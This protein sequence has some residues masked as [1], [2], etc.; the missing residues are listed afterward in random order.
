[1]RVNNVQGSLLALTDGKGIHEGCYR[2]R[3]ENR[4]PACNHQGML[5]L[6]IFTVQ[7]DFRQVED[8]KEIRVQGFIGQ[9]DPDDLKISQG[10]FIL[11]AEQGNARIAHGR[12]HIYPGGKGA[13]CSNIDPLVKQVIQYRNPQVGLTQ[14]INIRKH[15]RHM[16]L[17]TFPGLDDLVQLTPDIAPRLGHSRQEMFNP[18]LQALCLHNLHLKP[19]PYTHRHPPTTAHP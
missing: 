6:T 15:Q 19:I 10:T 5:G 9:A 1:M 11:Q 2:F 8:V 3:V 14:V 18:L 13:L 17:H 12:F 16:R 7:G 4:L